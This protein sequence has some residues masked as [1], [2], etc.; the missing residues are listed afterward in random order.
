M[1][2]TAP[3]E[4][5]VTARKGLSTETKTLLWVLGAALLV[6]LVLAIVFVGHPTDINN[7]K[8][9][10]MHWVKN[11][12][13]GFFLGPNKVWCDYPPAYLYLLGGVAWIYHLFD[14]AFA[15]WYSSLFTLTVKLPALFAEVGCGWLIY[16]LLR[17]HVGFG[18]ALGGAAIYLFNPSI[19]YD[20]AIAGQ[21][22]S[23][24]GFLQLA[25]LWLLLKRRHAWV[26]FLTALAILIKPQGLVLAGLFGLVILTRKDCKGIALGCAGGLLAAFL[27]TAPYVVPHLGVAG[28]FPWLYQH[29]QEQA[30]LYPF[31][32]IQAFNLWSLTGMWQPDSRLILGVP[33]R[34]W[35]LILFLGAYAGIL[36]AWWRRREDDA[37][38]YQ[39]AVLIMLAFFLL[40]T[41]M[42]ERYLH[43]TVILMTIPAVLSIR[44]RWPLGLFSFTFLI[45]VAYELKFPASLTGLS[46][47]L[48]TGPYRTLS[49]LNLA[50]F[51]YCAWLAFK[52]PTIERPEPLPEVIPEAGTTKAK[53]RE[54]WHDVV[55]RRGFAISA[56]HWPGW[57]EWLPVF[58]LTLV[59]TATR[60][61]NLAWP[62]QMIFD[63][64][65]HAR[66]ANEYI[67]GVR[68][69][70]W[71]HPPLAKLF[72]L[73]GVQI[74]GMT[75]YGWRIAPLIAGSLMLPV[76]YV[77]A[78]NILNDR[79]WALVATAL[80]A[81]DGV[82][83]VQSRTAMTNIF[84]TM[85]Q[86][87]T[88]TAFWLYWKSSS[89]EKPLQNQYWLLITGVCLALALATRWTSL[90]TFGTVWLLLLVR[91]LLPTIW[92]EPV[93]APVLATAAGPVVAE[94]IPESVEA[95]AEAA[96]VA[97]TV[98]EAAAETTAVQP[99]AEAAMTGAAPAA[100]VSPMRW[101]WDLPRFHLGF[102]ALA[103]LYL[104]GFPLA[105]YAI[106][107]LP[108][109]WQGHDWT[110]II[111][112]QRDIWHYHANLR[113][114]HPYYSAWYS[115]PFLYR[116]TWYYFKGFAD[117]TVGGIDAIGN[118]AIWWASLIGVVWA[119]WVGLQRREG[120]WLFA[121]VLWFFMY[122]PWAVS[123][124]ILNYSH[125]Y[126]E[127]IP[128]AIIAI[129]LLVRDLW[130]STLGERSVAALYLAT[131]VGL[132]IFFYPIW[133]GIPIPS[134]YFYMH[135]W[136]PKWV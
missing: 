93:T 63:E 100:E 44:W 26:I 81:M 127:A 45:N 109:H 12:T 66:T 5:E 64:V 74:N 90:W 72:I 57:K 50:L 55:Q 89:R 73:I 8:A 82:Y 71:V 22:N 80:L 119:F 56:P 28:V 76:F 75:S 111:R 14:P 16:V 49:L 120:N 85:F 94:P 62:P 65:Y 33:H 54:I 68:P 128:Y 38:L 32:S 6:K 21:I 118:P 87:A 83:F 134:W 116:P 97:A 43:Y 131:C 78:R 125:Y 96:A 13:G 102:W 10:A 133:T 101:A 36:W 35:G 104:L 92:R 113:D 48:A 20:T 98:A 52:A 79:R 126:F 24:I 58:G 135:I 4:H 29:F 37:S 129:T 1:A 132:F 110:E 70:E 40:P 117:G 121:V 107:Y 123:P 15:T 31:S 86:V 95:A 60:Y 130:R 108:F 88:M 18:A 9:W 39:A 106:S 124:R 11:G 41:R 67:F 99:A 27:T 114:P 19:N 46:Q 34:V 3:V 122:L 25:S 2:S 23:V 59:S 115:W 53:W 17:R 7:F 91:Y 136:F 84:A 42:H 61:Y 77:L 47:W 30:G 69:T 51:G 112:T 105:V 103:V